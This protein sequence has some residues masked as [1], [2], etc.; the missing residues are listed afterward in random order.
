MTLMKKLFYQSKN[1]SFKWSKYFDIYE[2]LFNSYKNKNITFVEIGIANGGSL[3][4]WKKYF[5]KSSRIIGIDINPECRIFEKDGYEIFIGNQSCPK[6][7]KFFFKKV[8][9]VD[10][11]LDDGGHTNL[12]QIITT[13]NTVNKINDNGLLVI[14][15]T[16]TSYSKEYNSSTKYSF[17]NF[18]KKLIDDIN[19]NSNSYLRKFIYSIF[20]FDSIIVF[21]INKNKCKFNKLIQNRGK[22]Y[23]I[24]NLTWMAN[25]LNINFVN[26]IFSYIPFISLRKIKRFI[27]NI[28]NNNKIKKYFT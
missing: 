2:E 21:K 17:V 1:N 5:G 16:H 6:F 7:W 8:G 10:I 25:E 24:K 13:L 26:K 14:E 20:F 15:D 9:N 22:N 3:E 23:N 4:I 12:D 19:L 27:K 11:I 18:A 28:I